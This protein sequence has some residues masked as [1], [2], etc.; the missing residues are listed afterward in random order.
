MS[1]RDHLIFETIHL[2]AEVTVLAPDTSE[3]R[4]LTASMPTVSLRG[5]RKITRWSPKKFVP[6]E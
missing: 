3:I 4:V 2:P 1:K 6:D 5:I